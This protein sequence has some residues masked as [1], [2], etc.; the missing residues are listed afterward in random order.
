FD[1]RKFKYDEGIDKYICPQGEELEYIGQ[2][3]DKRIYQENKGKC[4]GC[5]Y[6]GECTT[7]KRGRRVKRFIDEKEREKIMETYNSEEGQKIYKQRQYRCEGIFG[8]WKKNLRIS[9]FLVRGKRGA[10]AELGILASST[11]I[12]RA[13]KIMGQGRLMEMIA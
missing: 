10:N 7:H 11:N 6:Y 1:K 3:G 5:K 4:K 13:I 12:C 9:G 8:H 2:N